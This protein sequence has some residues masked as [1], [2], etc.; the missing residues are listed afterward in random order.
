MN[1][2]QPSSAPPAPPRSSSSSIHILF[3]LRH[4]N[5]LDEA[6]L[7]TVGAVR[8]ALEVLLDSTSSTALCSPHH[9]ISLLRASSVDT[10]LITT[11]PPSP[12][13]LHGV[14]QPFRGASDNVFLQGLQQVFMSSQH[15]QQQQSN[16][17][18]T[19]Y[20]LVSL[21]DCA[22]ALN[23][24]SALRPDIISAT[25]GFVWVHILSSV[26]PTLPNAL[27]PAAVSYMPADLVDVH[28]SVHDGVV[29][30]MLRNNNNHP[31]A[32]FVLSNTTELLCDVHPVVVS[33]GARRVVPLRWNVHAV[34]PLCAIDD[35]WL[36]GCAS[37]VVPSG[38]ASDG[39]RAA[40]AV[41]QCLAGRHEA[42]LVSNVAPTERLWAV[43]LPPPPSGTGTSPTPLFLMRY[44]A[45]RELVR[46]TPLSC[47]GY[48]DGDDV[49]DVCGF[50]ERRA[51]DALRDVPCSGHLDVLSLSNVGS[52]P[53]ET[54]L[55][56]SATF[57]AQRSAAA[58]S[59]TA[60]VE[61]AASVLPQFRNN[62]NNNRLKSPPPP[63]QPRKQPARAPRITKLKM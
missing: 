34:L 55:W 60:M 54:A 10:Q 7:A 13:R 17:H 46:S 8:H 61:C 23:T 1:I 51:L 31:G 41:L 16:N 35:A 63:R 48:G 56:R 39:Q 45:T 3:D 53:S 14:P 50:V 9:Y 47:G 32:T 24:L 62:N 22:S 12:W 28:R 57:S 42:L 19:T 29:A 38:R 58:E 40:K 44:L 30:A 18:I 11:I 52:D 20:V 4:P 33:V 2:M 5:C 59:T 37:Y 49:D 43:L 36:Y 21:M 27:P 15:Q 26:G 6:F 25:N